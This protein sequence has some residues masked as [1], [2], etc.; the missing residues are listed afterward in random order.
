MHS[1]W[2]AALDLP[3]QNLIQERVE[4]HIT[5]VDWKGRELISDK[6]ALRMAAETG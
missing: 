1:L 3:N 6:Q 4:Y 5:E 2:A